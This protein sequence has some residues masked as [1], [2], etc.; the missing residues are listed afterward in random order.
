MAQNEIRTI[1]RPVCKLCGSP[2]QP[3]HQ[4]LVD[5]LFAVPGKW[6]LKRCPNSDCGLSWLDPTPIDA[7][8]SLLYGTYHTHT[9]GGP[10]TA[11]KARLRALLL[12]LYLAASSIPNTVLGLAKARRRISHMFL[13][14]LPPGRILD[15]GCGAGEFLHRMQG[16]GWS[17]AGLDFD[18][19]AIENAKARFGLDLMHSDLAGANFPDNSFDAVTMNHVIEHVPDPVALLVEIKRVLKPGG[20]LVAT[21]PNIKSWGHEKF[22]TCWRGLEPPRHLQIFS[23]NALRYCSNLAA[24]KVLEATSSA[25]NAD[26]ILG[27]SCGVRQAASQGSLSQA[28]LEINLLRGLRCLGLQYIEAIQL[29]RQ[30]DRGEEAVLICQK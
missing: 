23:V 8:L 12:K 18:V 3:L 30:P 24:L 5:H 29:W 27:A 22:Q 2:G 1:P 7:D 13:D 21:T 6:Q 20:R 14:D 4:D 28:H 26:S 17:V 19:K 9:A 10:P 11:G 16:L 15:V 25:A